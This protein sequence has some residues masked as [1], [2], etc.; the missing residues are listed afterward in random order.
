MYKPTTPVVFFTFG[1]FVARQIEWSL[2]TFGTPAEGRGPLG[3]LD[4]LKKELIEISSNPKDVTEWVDA[5]FLSIDGLHRAGGTIYDVYAMT[6]STYRGPVPPL[7]FLTFL[8]GDLAKKPYDK[9]LWIR[10][11]H[12][13]I[14]GFEA[15]NGGQD[16]MLMQLFAKQRKNF[17]RDWPDWR[18]TD[19][20]KAVEHVK[21]KHD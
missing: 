3:P 21:G 13:S 7:R 18:L 4:H 14:E 16:E 8:V 19:P 1:E 9:G 15:A 11:L 10:A 2:H 12:I 6:F 5:I 17:N 20:N